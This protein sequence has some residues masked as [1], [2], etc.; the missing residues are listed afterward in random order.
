MY[1]TNFERIGYLISNL[2]NHFSL[3]FESVCD[4]KVDC[5]DMSDEDNC[6]KLELIENYRKAHS[7]SIV[8]IKMNVSV[9]IESILEIVEE[10]NLIKVKLNVIASWIDEKLTYINLNPKR[11]TVLF[12]EQKK[13]LWIPNLVFNNT[14][15]KFETHFRDSKSVAKVKLIPNAESQFAGLDLVVNSK[16]FDG[17][18]G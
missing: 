7:S 11:K 16:I 17:S 8:K 13:Y 14:N 10:K 5:D 4:S 15:D 18:E 12:P 9:D 1:S 3:P 6:D 2:C